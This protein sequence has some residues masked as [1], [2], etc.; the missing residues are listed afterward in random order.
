MRDLQQFAVLP[1]LQRAMRNMP[2]QRYRCL[3]LLHAQSH[4]GRQQAWDYLKHASTFHNAA[5]QGKM[6]QDEAE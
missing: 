2:R 6:K 4:K 5:G 3:N 1:S